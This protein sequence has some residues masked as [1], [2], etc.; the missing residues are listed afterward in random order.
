MLV[1]KHPFLQWAY[2]L[3][4]NPS[5]GASKGEGGREKKKGHFHLEF[6]YIQRQRDTIQGLRTKECLQP[7]GVALRK[8]NTTIYKIFFFFFFLVPSLSQHVQTC[9]G[10]EWWHNTGYS[11]DYPTSLSCNTCLSLSNRTCC[12]STVR[13]IKIYICRRRKNVNAIGITSSSLA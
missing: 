3:I 13:F 4:I 12:C 5:K 7:N 11:H 2:K 10:E 6:M 1:I 8:Q 9:K